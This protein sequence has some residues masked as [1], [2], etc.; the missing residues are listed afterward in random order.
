MSCFGGQLAKKVS[1][2]VNWLIIA[3]GG[4]VLATV[5]AVSAFVFLFRSNDETDIGKVASCLPASVVDT[6]SQSA[7]LQRNLGDVVVYLDASGGMAGYTASV[8][9]VIGNL[10]TITRDYT[11]GGLYPDG[12]KGK[13]TFRRFGEY[14]FSA[15]EPFAPREIE[16][17]ATFARPAAYTEQDSKIADLLKWIKH[18]RST[19]AKPLSVIVTDLMLDDRQAIDQFEVSVG[20]ALRN[21]IIED[22]LALGIM[23]VRVPFSGK[24]FIGATA[25]DATLP[26]R[27]LVIMMLGDPYQ[28]RRYYEYLATTQAAPFSEDT[29]QSERAFA[30]FGLEAGS[31]VLTEPKADGVSRS[32]SRLPAKTRVPGG[33]DI[34]SV[35]FNPSA[36]EKDSRS[37]ILLNLSANA[38]VADFEVIGNTP[39][40]SASVWKLDK[41]GLTDRKC[42]SGAAW[43]NV[44]GLPPSGWKVS[45]QQVTYRLTADA[46]EQAGLADDG[47]Y[48]LEIIA[49][50]QGVVQDHP[51]AAWMQEWSMDNSEIALRLTRSS[52]ATRIGV[53]GFEPLRRI[54]LAELTMPGSEKIKRSGTHLIIETEK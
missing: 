24:I 27:P 3:G 22:N 45:G 18:D 11:Q 26:N 37:G 41:G 17:F 6:R 8:P 34:P 4:A 43:L 16:D 21:M 46:M 36:K 31:I 35:R 42:K 20:G 23:A 52:G 53:P 5:V 19:G 49:G 28:V 38:G 9:N 14:Q 10:T 13:V 44:G 54:L 39:V 1:S 12:K 30:L 2:G 40:Y 7:S 48:L 47:L 25:V 29:S 32:F 33:D 15:A 51:A 50:Q